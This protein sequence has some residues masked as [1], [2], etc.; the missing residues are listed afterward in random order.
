M[1]G[2]ALSRFHDPL[3]PPEAPGLGRGFAF[4]AVAHVL[5][6]IAL[7]VGVAWHTATPPA[8]EAEL[9]SAVPQAAAPKEVLPDPPPE[10][11]VK[12]PEVQTQPPQP[13]AEQEQARVDAEIAIAKAKKQKERQAQEEK[14]KA[15][16]KKRL[17]D[18]KA[19]DDKKKAEQ[20]KKDKQE[21][22]DKE[23]QEKLDKLKADK[24]AK[25]SDAK[26]E[27]LRKQNLERMM[28]MAGASGGPTSTGTALKSSGPSS[29]YA[30]RIIARVKPN[31]IYSGTPAGNPA[32]T[33]EV[34]VGADGTI[35]GRKLIKPSG[36]PDWDN[37]VLRAIDKTE[38]LP[39]DTDGSVQPLMQLVFK[40]RD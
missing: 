15:L 40:P 31:I 6:F 13:T 8:F 36:D 30:G 9:W 20:D 25:D 1:T 35:L 16:E 18:K 4:A 32:A 34:R 11:E 26:R 7:S 28:G 27:A 29:T 33:V 19:A 37:A 14:E 10:P 24:A 12:Q 21:K 38:I 2:F 22:L 3:R 17:E 23:K 39:R 5:L